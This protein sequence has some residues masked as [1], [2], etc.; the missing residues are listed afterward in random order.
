[1]PGP[2]GPDSLHRTVPVPSPAVPPSVLQK[3]SVAD[4]VTEMKEYFR[5]FAMQGLLANLLPCS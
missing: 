4:Q 3:T 2:R 5:A 1:M